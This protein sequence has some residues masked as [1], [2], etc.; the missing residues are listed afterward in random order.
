VWGFDDR[1]HFPNQEDLADM[2]T[3]ASATF[4]VTNWDEK[5]YDEREGGPNLTRAVVTKGFSGDIE[6]EATVEYLMVHRP[7]GTASFVGVER[8]T[9]K[10]A[11]KSGSFVLEHRGTFEGGIAKAVCQVVAGSGTEELAG[12]RGEGS[13]EATGREAPFTLDYEFDE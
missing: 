6:G 11:G 13:F 10:L 8:I 7:E 3:R 9:G 1:Y 12:L 5:T 2:G 4:E